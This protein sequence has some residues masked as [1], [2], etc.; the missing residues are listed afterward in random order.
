MAPPER[1]DAARRLYA[2]TDRL[3]VELRVVE[4]SVASVKVGAAT[5]PES[6]GD[7]G[8][9]VFLIMMQVSQSAREDLEAVMETIR[10]INRA[11]RALRDKGH[12][13]GHGDL[14]FESLL[15]LMATL[16]AKQLGSELDALGEAG[17]IDNLRL[18]MA[19][20]RLSKM[21]STLSN[22]L[23]KCADTSS[24]IVQNLK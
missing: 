22:L 12:D 5:P 3:Q 6:D 14:D 19:M 8:A 11:K 7:I 16:Y 2:L 13:R 20:D 9:L 21:M 18:Q 1:A 15:H 4:Q 17:E 10:D 23:K 24:E